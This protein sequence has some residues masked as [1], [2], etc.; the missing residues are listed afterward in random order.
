MEKN[1]E[2]IRQCIE[3]LTFKLDKNN[4]ERKNEKLN[5]EYLKLN[6]ILS[7]LTSYLHEF[8]FYPSD[9]SGYCCEVAFFTSL[10]GDRWNLEKKEKVAFE[11]M[12][13]NLINHCQGN[14]SG[15]TKHAV[16]VTDN[17]DDDIANFWQPNIDQLKRNGVIVEVHLMIGKKNNTYE[18]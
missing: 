13:K 12:F 10:L 1:K 2:K 14:C 11:Q 18:L 9:I 17:W 16:I 3:T 8:N 7:E 4:L 6:R 5:N 15:K